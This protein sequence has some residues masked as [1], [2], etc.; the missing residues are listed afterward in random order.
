MTGDE[1]GPSLGEPDAESE[2]HPF[3]VAEG[4]P[5]FEQIDQNRRIV[6]DDVVDSQIDH[7][8]HLPGVVDGP[9]V[10]LFA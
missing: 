2:Q 3:Q 4:G 10:N 8:R 1:Q 5:L 7:V 6:G 9:D